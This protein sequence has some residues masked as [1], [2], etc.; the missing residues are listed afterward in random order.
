M[1]INHR[2]RGQGC[3]FCARNKLI[4]GVNDLQTANPTLASQWDPVKNGNLT[5]KDVA[6]NKNEKAWWI[7]PICGVSWEA[8]ISTRNRSKGKY[9][10]SC[11]KKKSS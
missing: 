7:C 11:N 5:P 4:R 3:T 9:C 1:T 6:A 2:T 8:L 10:R